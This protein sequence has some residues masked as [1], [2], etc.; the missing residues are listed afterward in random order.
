VSL[1]FRPLPYSLAHYL[2]YIA[3][4][5]GDWRCRFYF[6]RHLEKQ[7][8]DLPEHSKLMKSAITILIADRNPNVREFLKREMLSENYRAVC[9]EDAKTM[10][11]L[12]SG[13]SRVDVVIVDPDLP[14]MEAPEVLGK[15]W[16]KW[17]L[18][19][20][21]IHSLFEENGFSSRPDSALFIE[22]RG[23][24]I[25]AIKRVVREKNVGRRV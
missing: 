4:F 21:I 1:P 22:K 13:L 23:R 17:P 6:S 7:T 14:D 16:E 19:P 2:K 8:D 25:E 24:S 3:A 18:L 10:F 20:V 15:L 9:A 12:V 11:K 5:Y